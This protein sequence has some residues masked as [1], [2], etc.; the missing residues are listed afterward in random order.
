MYINSNITAQV[1]ADNLNNN[2]S[3][4][5]ASIQRLSSGSKI[6][7]PGQD[8]AGLAMST[9]FDSQISRISAA[10]GNVTNALSFTQTQDGYLSQVSTA[11]SRM[12]QLAI[13]AQDPTKSDSDRALY[14]TEFTQLS[15][16]VNDAATKTF[17]GVSLFS[18]APMQITTD[19]EG[20]TFTMPGVSL[21]SAAY[22]AATSANVSTIANS[23]TALTAV[24]AAINQLSSD[25]ATVGASETR[26]TYTAN[27]LSV[28]NENLSSADSAIKDVDVATEST[29]FAQENILTQSSVAMLAQANQIP[30]NVLKLLQ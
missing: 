28:T 15:S 23:T 22:T 14:N 11:L 10:Q 4:L 20:D 16:F 24:D 9:Q 7:Q 5:S 19:Y 8:P 6:S 30:Q 29:S 17:N 3:M 25:R 27:E 18:G 21:T 12:S 13:E 1:A 26:L 2:Q